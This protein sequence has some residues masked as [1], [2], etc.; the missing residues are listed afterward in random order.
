[1]FGFFVENTRYTPFAFL[2]A[3]GVKTIETRNKNML[4]ALIGK[5][6]AIV[7]TGNGKPVVIGY[8]DI[9]SAYFCAAADFRKYFNKH[10]VPAGSKYDCTTKGK[11]F[12]SLENPEFIKYPY[13]LPA[14]TVRHGRSYCE[15]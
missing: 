11:W 14:W 10:L 5:R 2:I 13:P 7:Q 8:V 12:Y 3:A 15:F 4:K 6:V 1:M 9:T